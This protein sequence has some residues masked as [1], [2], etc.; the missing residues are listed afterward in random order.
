METPVLTT[1]TAPTFADLEPILAAL[2]QW[3]AGDVDAII[4]VALPS[5][6]T[7]VISL[8]PAIWPRRRSSGVASEDATVAGSAPGRL[9]ETEIIG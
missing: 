9:A 1:Q 3:T 5:V 6:L 7:E 8:T 4:R 2:A